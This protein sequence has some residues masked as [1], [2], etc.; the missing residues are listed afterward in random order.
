MTSEF[1]N[2]DRPPKAHPNA[3][4]PGQPCATLKVCENLSNSKASPA[5]GQSRILSPA[6]RP[7]RSSRRRKLAQ[8]T[9]PCRGWFGPGPQ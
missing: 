5:T 8:S 1:V 4:P 2:L 6:A 3:P 7:V 9:Q